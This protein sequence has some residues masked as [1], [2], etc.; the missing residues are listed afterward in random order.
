VARRRAGLGSQEQAHNPAEA[1]PHHPACEWSQIGILT[2]GRE[3][4]QAP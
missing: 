1:Q 2:K 4:S 3:Y